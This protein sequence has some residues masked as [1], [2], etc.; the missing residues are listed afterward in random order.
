MSA[1]WQYFMYE[2]QGTLT[3]PPTPPHNRDI[4][5]RAFYGNGFRSAGINI[6][7]HIHLH[8][9]KHIHTICHLLRN[10]CPP[11][12]VD[13]G[14]AG[15]A[16]H[17]RAVQLHYTNSSK[18]TRKYGYWYPAVKRTA[19]WQMEKCPS[20]EA[21]KLLKQLRKHL[22]LAPSLHALSW[23][24]AELHWADKKFYCSLLKSNDGFICFTLFP[25]L[26]AA[27]LPLWSQGVKSVGCRLASYW[28]FHNMPLSI[29]SVTIL[30]KNA[31]GIQSKWKR[32][33]VKWRIRKPHCWQVKCYHSIFFQARQ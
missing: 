6:H 23:F 17:I 21:T 11:R 22:I 25:A 5:K 12:S 18:V 32:K 1:A 24:S 29:Q 28:L 19:K 30:E 8:A 2:V 33:K 4:Q 15:M 14:E 3:C 27:C 7:V 31:K 13:E 9:H 20:A 26:P 10:T 16:C